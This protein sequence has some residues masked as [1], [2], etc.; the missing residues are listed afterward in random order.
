MAQILINIPDF[1]YKQILKKH[2]SKATIARTFQNGVVLPKGHGRLIDAD[3]FKNYC[4]AGL[5]NV[6]PLFKTEKYRKLAIDITQGIIADVDEM[7]TII[8]AD[9]EET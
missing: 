6:K 3:E 8:E 1:L 4:Q 7:E 5:E 9:K 2:V